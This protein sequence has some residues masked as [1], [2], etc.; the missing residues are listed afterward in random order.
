MSVLAI[1]MFIGGGMDIVVAVLLLVLGA[2]TVPV[3]AVIPSFQLG[4]ILLQ[5]LS[6]G[7]VAVGVIS[8]LLGYGLWKGQPWAWIWTFISSNAGLIVSIAGVIFGIGIVGL[9]VYS[10]FIY[11]LTRPGVRSYFGKGA[12]VAREVA[13][14][15]VPGFERQPWEETITPGVSQRNQSQQRRFAAQGGETQKLVEMINA[16]FRSKL[17]GVLFLVA[18]A[19]SIYFTT[20]AEGLYPNYNLQTNLVSDLGVQSQSALPWSASV[21]V[22]GAL[23]IVASLVLSDYGKRHRLL[24]VTFVLTGVGLIGLAAFNENAFHDVHL[25]LSFIAFAFAGISSLLACFG[26]VKGLFRY[27]SVIFG[28]MMLVGVVILYAGFFF[29]PV[30][31]VFFALGQ[32]FA[33]RI[34]L[35]PV[36]IWFIAFGAYLIGTARVARQE[37]PL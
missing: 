3:I 22:T 4:G 37:L 18:W 23:V 32:G 5:L 24:L 29:V 14:P 8:F 21:F 15:P 2:V 17:A 6:V 12:V 28:G 16:E 1:L 25:I 20:V 11:Y 27:V 36:S 19:Q 13:A 9:V 33:E 31:S 34:V 10:T 26:P 30:A 35:L 7:I